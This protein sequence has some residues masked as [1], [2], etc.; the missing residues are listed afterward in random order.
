MAAHSPRR[1]EILHAVASLT[2][3]LD[4]AVARLDSFSEPRYLAGSKSLCVMICPI[5]FGCFLFE[6]TFLGF[7]RA[8]HSPKSVRSLGECL[9]Q[10][11][12]PWALAEGGWPWAGPGPGQ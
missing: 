11:A 10:R 1:T 6:M 2:L 8:W 7:S 9:R 5:L 3:F 12:S 4:E